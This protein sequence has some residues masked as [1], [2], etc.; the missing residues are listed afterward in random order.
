MMGKWS[1]RAIAS[2]KWYYIY[3]Y[4]NSYHLSLIP[5]QKRG[6][7][8]KKGTGTEYNAQP[9]THKCARI[10]YRGQTLRTFLSLYNKI[11]TWQITWTELI[12]HK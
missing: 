3:K 1:V 11:L 10:I 7:K 8:R 9:F 4:P 2:R 12:K 5:K 6:E